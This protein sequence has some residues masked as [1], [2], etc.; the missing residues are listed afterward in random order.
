MNDVVIS[1]ER[2]LA[3]HFVLKQNEP[4]IQE[5]LNEIFEKCLKTADTSIA[6]CFFIT[7]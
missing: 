4:K 5:D 7:S 3:V 2:V 1:L 6:S